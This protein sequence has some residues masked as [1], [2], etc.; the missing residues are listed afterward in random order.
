VLLGLLGA[1]TAQAGG[2]RCACDESLNPLDPS[3]APAEL[4]LAAKSSEIVAA[5]DVGDRAIAALEFLGFAGDTLAVAVL[6]GPGERGES[7]R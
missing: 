1:A 6:G 7:C 2:R 3:Q 4:R 5:F